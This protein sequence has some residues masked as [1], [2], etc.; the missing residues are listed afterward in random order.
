MF[1]DLN[2]LFEELNKD[3]KNLPKDSLPMNNMIDRDIEKFVKT[4]SEN[5]INNKKNKK[6]KN[7][8]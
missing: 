6:K 7:K 5:T 4:L 2:I 1:E 8:K 3:M